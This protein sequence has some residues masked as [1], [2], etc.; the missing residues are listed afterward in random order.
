MG[1]KRILQTYIKITIMKTK[2]LPKE[3]QDFIDEL[4]QNGESD[5]IDSHDKIYCLSGYIPFKTKK[6]VD[7]TSSENETI[8]NKQ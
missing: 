4:R 7:N 8:I 3:L 6:R 2:E 5:K 1:N